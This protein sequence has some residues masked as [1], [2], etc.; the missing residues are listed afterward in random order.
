MSKFVD[1]TGQKFGKLIVLGRGKDYICPGTKAKQPRWKVKC[2]DCKIEY[3]LFKSSFLATKNQNCNQHNHRY[4][5]LTRQKFGKLTV[6]KK[7]E[8]YY[9]SPKSKKKSV[10]WICECDCDTIVSVIG[11]HLK[12]GTIA[13]CKK[14]QY[15]EKQLNGYMSAH[16]LH[17]VKQGAKRRNIYFN[18]KIDREYL[19]NLYL[20][21][22]KKCVLT[23]LPIHFAET[24]K[25]EISHRGT[26][27]S[28]DRINS[29]KGYIKNNIQW[30]HKDINKMKWNLNQKDFIQ[31]CKNIWSY[32]NEKN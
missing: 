3:V 13:Q 15:K 20:K 26:T 11:D 32:N 18:P 12:A 28:L 22:N 25:E 6:I 1:L 21:Q 17:C 16:R 5:D 29:A 14:C 27:A 31:I 4:I 24:T 30:V 19:W 10:R 2:E 7:D 8:K 23:N 9:I